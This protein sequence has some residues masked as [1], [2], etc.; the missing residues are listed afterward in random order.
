VDFVYGIQLLESVLTNLVQLLKQQ[1]I[2]ILM[3]NVQLLVPAQSKQMLINLLVKDVLQ[4][5]LAVLTLYKNNVNR[6]QQEVL[7]SG[8]IMMQPIQFVL[9]NHVLQL[10]LLLLHHIQIVKVT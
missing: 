2:T 1:Q 10:P 5:L 7:V 3:L 6:M 8:M 4:E 9:I